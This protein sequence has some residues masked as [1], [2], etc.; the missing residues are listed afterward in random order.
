MGLIHSVKSQTT[1]ATFAPGL[2]TGETFVCTNSSSTISPPPIGSYV[3]DYCHTYSWDF[4][5]CVTDNSFVF[6]VDSY[7]GD[8]YDGG[9]LLETNEQGST[10]S[11]SRSF[12]FDDYFVGNGVVTE[13]KYS[14]ITVLANNCQIYSELI[15]EHD[16]SDPIKPHHQIIK[17]NKICINSNNTFA[18][19]HVGPGH[20]YEWQL[21]DDNNHIV[22]S[23][24][25]DSWVWDI[26]INNPTVAK[27]RVR[28]LKCD[29]RYSNWVTNIINVVQPES[30]NFIDVKGSFCAG[31]TVTLET[32]SSTTHEDYDWEIYYY[33]DR[34]DQLLSNESNPLTFTVPSG[35][36]GRAE[37]FVK[38][39]N[40][41]LYSNEIYQAFN[42][43]NGAISYVNSIRE[44]DNYLAGTNNTFTQTK[45]NPNVEFRWTF[46]SYPQIN[47]NGT[48]FQ[49]QEQGF[50][51]NTFTPDFGKRSSKQNVS[52]ANGLVKYGAV[53][54]FTLSLEARTGCGNWELINDITVNNVLYSCPSNGGTGVGGF[55]IKLLPNP[56]RDLVLFKFPNHDGELINIRIIDIY[57]V[58][59]RN[60]NTDKPIETLPI[61]DLEGGIYTVVA[62]KNNEVVTEHLQVMP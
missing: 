24:T 23:E 38:A 29:G 14:V 44:P 3:P 22:I 30:I 60:F 17:P 18:T 1:N 55:F 10:S 13:I 42:T 28:S 47:L 25:S 5:G 9:L 39:Q 41:C 11:S 48:P 50:E 56:A 57:G 52:C 4:P 43:A 35:A 34:P 27:V 2:I 58:E 37:V 62:R 20:S 59:R 16:N 51:L 7:D 33:G 31:E 40:N 19:G 45:S 6:V 46:R 61:N 26:M 12:C 54:S 36:T 15:V 53:K 32:N 21:L 8:P 49:Q